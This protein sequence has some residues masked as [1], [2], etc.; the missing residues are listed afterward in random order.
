MAARRTFDHTKQL[1]LFGGLGVDSWTEAIEEAANV[2]EEPART[3]DPR[4]LADLPTANGR[5]VAN[6]EPV[7]TDDLRSAGADWRSTVRT[8]VGPEDGLPRRLGDGDERMGAPA[9]PEPS[10]I[11]PHWF[12]ADDSPAAPTRDFRITEAHRIG[13]G[14]LREKALANLEAIRTLKQLEGDD[15]DATDV[16]RAILAHYSGWGALANVFHPQPSREWKEIAL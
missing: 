14:S 12:D 11:V 13:E 2:R 1:D 5:G 16:E 6:N 7:G 15:R 10:A 9:E 4:T 8:G 3:D